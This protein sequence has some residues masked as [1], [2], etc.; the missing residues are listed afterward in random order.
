MSRADLAD[1]PVGGGETG[2]LI[3]AF[4]WAA[5]PLG[6]LVAWPQS[7][8]TAVDICLAVPE[9]ATVLWGA[10]RIQL[11]NDAYAATPPVRHPAM[12]GRPAL[13]NWAADRAIL[14]PAL[15]RLFADG[16]PLV[17][18]DRPVAFPGADG[19]MEE[20]TFTFT[21]SAIRD[22]RGA[23]G[24][25][26]ARVV[27]TTPRV[28]AE[29][30]LQESAAR[31]RALFEAIDQGFCV[32]EVL[33]D[34]AGGPVDYR[35]VE[36]NPAFEALTGLRGALGRTARALVPGLEAWWF[37]TYGR[38]ALTGEPVRFEH[39][40][41]PLGRWFDVHA[42]RLGGAG[43]RRV[44]LVFTNITERKR[45]EAERERL[46]AAVEAERARLEELFMQ[47]PA[48]ICLLDGPDHVFTLANPPY[49]ALIGRAE[50]LGRPVR[51][52]FPELP[53]QGIIELLDRVY[54]TGEAFVGDEVPMRLDRDG[55]GAP[56]E[57]YF[58]FVYAPFRAVDGAPSGI[59]VHAYEVTDH[60]RARLAAEEAVRAR[61]TF[62]SI[63]AHELRTPI[64]ALKGTAQLLL[65]RQTR[66][67]LD[68][69]HLADALRKLDQS[70][71]RLVELTG[72]LLDVARIRT[73]QLPLDP[74][75][76]DLI[77]LA[78]TAVAQARTRAD[79]G[80][81][82]ALDAPGALP[83]VMADAGRIE[84]V[85]TN[86]LDNA[87]KYSPTGGEVAVAV[88]VEGEGAAVAVRDAGIGLPPGAA[89]AIF[90]PFGRA[91]NAAASGLPGMGLGLFICRS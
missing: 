75:P 85:L 34:D 81:R 10:A 64:T 31:Y 32:I 63:A 66:G 6:P 54:R 69:D 41:A 71:D 74:R 90:A 35:F 27:E 23:V 25:A 73:G 7:L 24:G 38:V 33:L 3:R 86:L 28:R 91:T 44:A 15:D 60:V 47:A 78:G 19:R 70:A 48:A 9:P 88:R 80:H 53:G 12:L 11:Y 4:D 18:A 89:G 49:L 13:E 82:L 57:V 67:M 20:R 29:A 56:E 5:T 26:L 68:A 17:V 51:E 16:A 43:S 8:R 58:T 21:F 30:A 46:L 72:D 76:T 37:A 62:L 59:F 50:V 52:V 40:A 1:W 45:A 39:Y 83:P 36:A 79:D 61:D 87:L 84:Q 22:E 65:R 55:D 2:A 77:A 42:S 14:A